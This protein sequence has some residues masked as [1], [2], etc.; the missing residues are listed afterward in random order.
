MLLYTVCAVVAI[1]GNFF[2]QGTSLKCQPLNSLRIKEIDQKI[3]IV[4][5]AVLREAQY[6]LGCHYNKTFCVQL[7]A[8]DYQYTSHWNRE[9]LPNSIMTPYLE[10]VSR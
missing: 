9:F 6:V 2:Y 5:P 4:T 8:L 7:D 10:S 3:C 1:N